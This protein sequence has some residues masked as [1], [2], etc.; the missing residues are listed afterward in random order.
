MGITYS[1]LF[2]TL[3]SKKMN[4]QSIQTAL[5]LSSTTIARLGKDE[6]VSLKTID[7]ICTLLDCE[8]EDV[9]KHVKTATDRQPGDHLEYKKPT[10]VKDTA[11]VAPA[12]APVP[13]VPD[14][15]DRFLDL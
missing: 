4:R 5:K 9:V 15:G 12:V 11:P 13:T 3:H 8:I 10:D 7:D 1:S 14:D 6:Y 2:A